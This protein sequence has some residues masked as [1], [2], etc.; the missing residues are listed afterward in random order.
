MAT[1]VQAV[2]LALHYGETYLGVTDIFGRGRRP[3]FGRVFTATQGFENG[4][5]FTARRTRHSPAPPWVIAYAGGRRS[6]KFSFAIMASTR[7]IY[8]KWPAI[9]AG[10][11]R[12]LRHASCPDDA[13][14]LGHSRESLSLAIRSRVG[15]AHWPVESGYSRAPQS[16][17]TPDA[18]RIIDPNPV[19]V[20]LPKALP[21]NSRGTTHSRRALKIRTSLKEMIDARSA[22]VATAAALAARAEAR[23]CRWHGRRCRVSA[24]MR[25]SSAMAG[26]CRF[27][28]GGRQ[29]KQG[30]GFNFDV[31]DLR[32]ISRTT[33]RQSARAS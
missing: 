19:M 13:E 23:S 26:H 5:E 27:V 31:L 24:Q 10:E 6:R 3:A 15:R 9:N 25:R 22:T 8:L 32:S 20:L 7:S 28:C 29:A 33:G 21:A 12:Q 18:F 1:L 16:M 4:V 14:R 2:R 17:P 30:G 11:R